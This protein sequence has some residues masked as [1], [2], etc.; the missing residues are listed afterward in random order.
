MASFD[1]RTFLRGTAA[2]GA[3]GVGGGLLEACGG[4]GSSTITTVSRS[5]AEVIGVSTAKPKMGGSVAFGTEAEETGMDPTQAHYDSTGVCYARAVFDPLAIILSDGTPAPYLAES[6][7]PN[8]SYTA[9]TITV[10]PNVVFHDGTP[11]DG[12]ALL[13]CMREFLK[14]GLTNFAFAGYMDLSNPNAAVT[15]VGPRSIVM[16]MLK[17]WV[18]FA[19]WLA[20]YIGGQCA[21]MFSPKAYLASEANFNTHPVGT[22]PFV[23]KDWQP[24]NFFT[25]TKNPR[26]WRKD[27][28]GQQ[29]PYLDSWTFRP[30]PNVSTRYSYLE[31]GTIQ[32]MH[33]DDDPTILEIGANKSLVA[34]GDDEL[35]VGEPDIDFAMINCADPLLKDIRLRQALAY[36]TNQGEY[37]QVIGR[38]IAKPTNGVFPPPSPYASDTGYPTY[39]PK[40]A[41]S[42]IKSWMA[43]H[44]GKAPSIQ[45]TTTASNTSVTDASIIQQMWETVGFQVKVATVQQAQLITDA[46]QGGYQ[47]FSWRQFAS[48]NPDLNY[49]FWAKSGGPINFARNYDDKIQ[50]A[51]DRARQSSD[52]GV[53]TSAYEEVDHRL[54]VDLPYIYFARD[55]WYVAAEKKVMNWNNPT[56]PAGQRGLTMLSGIVWPTEVWLDR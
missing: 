56:S 31:T 15:Q 13:F 41:K 30:Q 54:A 38:N 8:S 40:K 28:W 4:S 12:Q 48:V 36:G 44:G 21:Y 22:G 16:H 7:T 55:V 20:G 19:Y 33:T 45:F 10:R 46:L 25:L 26:Y 49:I 29:L 24:G 39:D 37:L 1:R 32:M 3:A 5:K 43:D 51:L 18:P 27:R 11:C 9:W 14:S 50:A 52:P 35:S 42:L 17:P 6:I 53:Q 34:L 2:L 23:Y 47:I